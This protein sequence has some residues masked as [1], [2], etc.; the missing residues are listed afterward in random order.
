MSTRK[1][2]SRND[3]YAYREKLPFVM[4]HTWWNVSPTGNYEADYQTGQ[5]YAAAFWR[6]C[7]KTGFAGSDLAQIL[8]AM[9]DR[10]K[11]SG[12]NDL[13]GIEIGFIRGIGDIID[14]MKVVP[15][16]T[17][18]TMQSRKRKLKVRR[19]A[20][21]AFAKVTQIF[22]DGKQVQS[23]KRNEEIQKE[24]AENNRPAIRARLVGQKA[25]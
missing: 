17:M 5:E 1:I 10:K 12:R 24:L 2:K 19:R 21:N 8:F 6:V 25:A 14:I 16:L 9:H 15:A 13:S 20:V 23:R 4:R 22:L 18:M 3:R 11:S 7:G